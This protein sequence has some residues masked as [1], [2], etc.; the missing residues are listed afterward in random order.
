MDRSSKVVLFPHLGHVQNLRF[1]WMRRP[2]MAKRQYLEQVW[3]QGRDEQA[4]F[5]VCVYLQMSPVHGF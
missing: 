1:G 4:L 3:G 2:M 5:L